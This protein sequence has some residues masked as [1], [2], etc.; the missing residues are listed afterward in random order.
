MSV[1]KGFKITIPMPFAIIP[2][3]IKTT[4]AS[5]ENLGMAESANVRASVI[6]CKL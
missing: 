5:L 4:H 3:G 2:K 1:L 6:F